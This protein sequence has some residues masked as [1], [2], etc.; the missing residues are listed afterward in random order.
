MA[1]VPLRTEIQIAKQALRIL[2]PR[3]RRLLLM[4]VPP[5]LLVAFLE[6]LGVAS[7]APFIALLSEPERF[8]KHRLLRWAYTTFSFSSTDDLFFFVGLGILF[9][10]VLSNFTAGA[11]MWAMLRF[12]WMRNANLSTRLLRSYLYRPYAFFLE[13]NVADLL[14]K[15]LS[16][17]QSISLD[18]MYHMMQLVSRFFAIT[19]I[20]G[21]LFFIEPV[22]AGGALVVFAGIY[23]GLFAF[24]RRRATRAGRARTAADIRRFKIAMEALNGAK[25]IK[26]Y[27]LEDAVVGRFRRAAVESATNAVNAAS[28]TQIPRYALETVAF[29]GVLVM[30]L[31]LLK[32]R[33]RLGGALPLLGIY[34]FASMRLLPALQ[35]VFA[36]FN[37]LRF[38][39]TVVGILA[40]EFAATPPTPPP[41][42]ADAPVTF[43]RE[44]RLDGISFSY[45]TSPKPVLENITVVLERGDWV[46]FV[47]PTGSGKSTLVDIILSLLEP[48][49][50]TITIDGVELTPELRRGW[51][52]HTA[53]VPQQITLIDDTIAANICF[54]VAPEQIDQARLERVARVA[55]IHDFIVSELPDG[56]KTTAGDRGIRL[57]GGQRQRI[58]IARALYRNPRFLVLDEATSA[59]DGAT[60]LAFFTSLREQLRDVT[61]VSITH[62][63]TTTRNFD[64]VYRL[65]G[66]VIVDELHPEA[67]IRAA[68]PARS[69]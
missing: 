27:R 58:G 36:A 55:Q 43:D 35:A 11:T 29:G 46:G 19:L 50:G 13:R 61:V 45:A 24:S 4:L 41:A 31:Y 40:K 62:R 14:R 42:S 63:L 53:Y 25:E 56:Y 54:G 18:V 44:L 49:G 6:V 33:H 7:L 2:E 67:L 12:V 47:G 69:A 17:V 57:S 59:L 65:E 38:N 30:M 10:L 8:M 60:E 5:T 23:G 37:S 26:L 39:S 68:E 20:G 9:L 48:T 51:Q 15:S 34:A 32:T 64:R 22:L 21:T 28:L 52:A 3:E 1:R 66:G 16:D